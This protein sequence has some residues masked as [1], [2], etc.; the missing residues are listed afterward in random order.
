MRTSGQLRRREAGS[1]PEESE[2]HCIIVRLKLQLEDP[3]NNPASIF[4][5]DP[6]VQSMGASS[7]SSEGGS[8]TTTAVSSSHRSHFMHGGGFSLCP[9]H[10]R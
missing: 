3:E 8:P 2:G 6:L 9:L 7:S 1:V 10:F 4:L 5:F